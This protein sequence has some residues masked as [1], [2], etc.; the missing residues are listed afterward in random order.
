MWA[1]MSAS[2][3][4]LERFP[5]TK[6]Y[7][8]GLPQG[9]QSFPEL[10]VHTDGLGSVRD[11]IPA[12]YDDLPEPLAAYYRREI[13]HAWVPEVLGQ[14]TTL[15]IV[16]LYGLDHL[17]ARSRELAKTLYDG[18]VLKH[19]VR[20]MSPT[21]VVMG[22]QRRWSA[23]RRGTQMSSTPVQREG[24]LHFSEVVVESPHP[25]F[26]RPFALALNPFLELAIASARGRDARSELVE[27][28]ST[29]M[30]FQGCWS[31]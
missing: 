23:M 22:T 15:M 2:M 17:V 21:L 31:R 8:E 30:R 1:M 7:L 26:T 5:E 27:A 20:I 11:L 16:D 28:T 12:P 19:L 14:C 6:R 18:P 29:K 25:V 3:V 24:D 4:M 10:E 9:L 13:D